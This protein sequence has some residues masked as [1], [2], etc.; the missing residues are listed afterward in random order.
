MQ[1]YQCTAPDCEFVTM[2]EDLEVCPRCGN[3]GFV[4]V[5]ESDITPRGWMYLCREADRAGNWKQAYDFCARGAEKGDPDCLCEQGHRML[6]GK[7]GPRDPEQAA[8]L[9]EQAA[10]Q[11][12]AHGRFLL[13]LCYEKGEGRPQSWENAVFL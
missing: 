10:A 6:Y 2:R 11:D 8:A 13:G 9:F 7:G 1:Y 5:E 4:P 3:E 12:S